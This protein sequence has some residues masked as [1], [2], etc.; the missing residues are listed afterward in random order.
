MFSMD[1]SLEKKLSRILKRGKSVLLLG[2]RQT[3][4]TTLIGQYK[5][6][7]EVTLLI[8][9]IRRQYEADPDQ[10][11]RE[12]QALEKKAGKLPLVVIDEV[13]KVPALMDAIQYLVDKQLGQFILTGSSARKLRHNKN[14]NLL[15]GRVIQLYLDPINLGEASLPYPL[16][17]NFLLYGSLPA[18]Y[19]ESDPQIREEELDSYVD[20]YLEDEVRSEAL[21]RDIGAFENFLKLAAI[22]SGHIVNFDKIS[23]DIGVARTTISAYY[24]ILEDCLIAERIEPYTT[25]KTR[26]RLT[27]SPK[28]I[29]FDLG[30]RR[31]AAKEP[32]TL[33]EKY[34]GA[35][36][37]QFVGLELIRWSRL[38]DAKSTVHF[39]RDAS[40]LE[41]DWLLSRDQDLL[42]IEVKWTKTPSR[43][44][45]KHL[46]VFLNEY[47]G[48]TQ[49]YVVCQ[50]SQPQILLKG[51]EAISWKDLIS[52][53]NHW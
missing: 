26:K 29:L 44:D 23:Q 13:Q 5:A 46:E 42:P 17:E 51:V 34:L 32:C 22:E 30:L 16:I 48:A 33:P 41:V 10:L 37:E 1:R 53:L 43:R 9:K 36:F 3:G 11:I 25:S 18:I 28:Y 31:L 20:L 52:R 14:V 12:V 50:V 38:Q 4:K 40:G 7:L 2:P 39:W 15:P 27:K 21:V 19:L 47:P 49:A 8:S 35:L 24:Q 6:D 45:A